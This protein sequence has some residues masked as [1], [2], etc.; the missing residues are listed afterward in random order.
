[1]SEV[2]VNKH[3]IA[4]FFSEN[5]IKEK[6]IVSCY[7]PK[8]IAPALQKVLRQMLLFCT[9][10][11]DYALGKGEIATPVHFGEENPFFVV[12]FWRRGGS[13][14]WGNHGSK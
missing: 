9:Q 8:I 3:K 11:C 12:D 7:T 13:W 10:K 4:A 6:F 5:E 2:H 1:M 14:V